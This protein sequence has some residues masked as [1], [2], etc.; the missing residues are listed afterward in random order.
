MAADTQGSAKAQS[1]T[2]KRGMAR[3]RVL[4]QHRG[5]HHRRVPGEDAGVVGH[6]Q[7]A[8]VGW[9][10]CA[11]P[12]PPPAT[13]GRRGT[14]GT[15]R[16]SRRTPRRSPTRPRGSLPSSR[17]SGE[18]ERVPR[19]AR[20][21]ARPRGRAPPG[22]SRP[23]SSPPRRRRRNEIAG[24]SGNAPLRGRRAG[25]APGAAEP[26]RRR[27]ALLLPRAGP[28]AQAQAR[29]GSSTTPARA[30]TVEWR[31]RKPTSSTSRVMSTP[32]P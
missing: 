17:C 27:C 4:A 20:Q 9:A 31:G 1:S 15:A 28:G 29:S 12:P 5:A 10:R 16:R 21:R 22:R 26:S 30:S 3:Q 18:L 24:P 32:R 23:A 2:R 7:G 14:R 25:R 8:A 6:E 13:S 19:V 11:R